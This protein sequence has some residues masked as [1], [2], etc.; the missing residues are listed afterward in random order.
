MSCAVG[1][2]GAL[3]SREDSRVTDGTEQRKQSREYS[4]CVDD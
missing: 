4:W 1:W 3:A 2:A